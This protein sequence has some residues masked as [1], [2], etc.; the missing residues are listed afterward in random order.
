MC[1]DVLGCMESFLPVWLEHKCLNSKVDLEE[2]KKRRKPSRNS[3]SIFTELCG[4]SK[5]R[6]ALGCF[7]HSCPPSHESVSHRVVL[8]MR[9]N[10]F[11]SRKKKKTNKKTTSRKQAERSRSGLYHGDHPVANYVA[12]LHPRSW[13]RKPLSASF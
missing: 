7:S 13:K 3:F 1:P 11:I 5:D 10:V 8:R 2:K 4:F 9:R 12:H 6:P